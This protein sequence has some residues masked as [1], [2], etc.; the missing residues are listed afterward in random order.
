MRI[1]VLQ[2]HLSSGLGYIE[3]PAVKYGAHFDTRMPH[4]E[5]DHVLPDD[6]SG[7]DGFIMMGGAM[8]AGEV[9]EHPYLEHAATLTRQF[10]EAGKPVLGICLGS[11]IIARAFGARVYDLAKPEIGYFEIAPT[12]EADGDPLIGQSHISPI[13]LAEFHS[14]TFDIPEAGTPLL[15]GTGDINQSFRVSKATYAFQPHFEVSPA[16]I[17]HWVELSDA[18]VP[19]HYPDLPER[20]PDL[21]RHHHRG[22]HD[23]CYRVAD[24]WFALAAGR[25][26]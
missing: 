19:K 12:P 9:D 11:Q 26:P 20:L 16:M 6:D 7:F 3:E 23:F 2:N 14:Q 18:L 1:L 25:K 10:T 8:N 13:F 17:T 4:L 24:A 15:K 22:S 5:T 21:I